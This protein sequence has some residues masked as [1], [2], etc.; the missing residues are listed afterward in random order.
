MAGSSVQ[1]TKLLIGIDLYCL[2]CRHCFG[3]DDHLPSLVERLFPESAVLSESSAERA[4]PLAHDCSVF[5]LQIGDADHSVSGCT[6]RYQL[7]LPVYTDVAVRILSVTDHIPGVELAAAER[8]GRAP[9]ITGDN[10]G[11]VDMVQYQFHGVEI[12]PGRVIPVDDQL[13]A[14]LID[15]VVELLFHEAGDHIDLVNARLVELAD[16]PLDQGLP[17]YLQERLGR[18]QVDGHHP[19][20]ESRCQNDR[21]ARSSLLSQLYGLFSQLHR[22]IQISRFGKIS[23]RPVDNA[24]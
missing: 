17:V 14:V 8:I 21:P 23:Q 18:L 15:Q 22:V 13:H 9:D 3:R 4:D 1:F 10:I 7:P 2:S 19:H 6:G 12:V 5:P 11:V 24:Q 16:L 20:A